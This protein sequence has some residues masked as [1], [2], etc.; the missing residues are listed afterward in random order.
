MYTA[1]SR[2][3]LAL[4]HQRRRHQRARALPR[5]R[6]S[7]GRL[8]KVFAQSPRAG[9]PF[10]LFEIRSLR[11]SLKARMTDPSPGAAAFML[12]DTRLR[13][14]IARN[15]AAPCANFFHAE[16]SMI[17]CAGIRHCGRPNVVRVAAAGVL[18]SLT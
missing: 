16:P 14:P 9:N 3:P 11:S 8:V 13:V 4:T 6:L 10:V 5:D 17:L 1:L 15:P 2:N 18:E 7:R 12:S